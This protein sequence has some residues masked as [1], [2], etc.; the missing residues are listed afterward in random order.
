MGEIHQQALRDRNLTEAE[1]TEESGSQ[2][3]SEGSPQSDI[4]ANRVPNWENEPASDSM[5]DNETLER[6]KAET[7]E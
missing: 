6:I 1:P 4:L 3:K 2:A 7:E 5:M